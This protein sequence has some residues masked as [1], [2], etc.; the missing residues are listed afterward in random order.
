MIFSDHTRDVVVDLSKMQPQACCYQRGLYEHLGVD[1]VLESHASF[2]SRLPAAR[3]S[4]FGPYEEARLN[5]EGPKA[6]IGA[7]SWGLA[8]TLE[9]P[10]H[11]AII[12]NAALRVGRSR[13]AI[14]T[15][16]TLR[17]VPSSTPISDS[18]VAFRPD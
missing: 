3:K 17:H 2:I 7:L 1:F 15:Y 9:V 6:N 10:E 8:E 16:S 4:L 14:I 5:F 18:I 11:Q 12:I 13:A